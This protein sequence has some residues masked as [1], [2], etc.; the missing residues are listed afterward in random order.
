MRDPNRI[1]GV[2]HE[3]EDIWKEFPDLRLGQILMSAFFS[4]PELYF[5]EDEELVGVLREKLTPEF[6]ELIEE[7]TEERKKA[8]QIRRRRLLQKMTREA[9]EA[10]IYDD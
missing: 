8:D 7:V 4:T 3:I 1:P 10:G 2:I 6:L 9:Q 5:V